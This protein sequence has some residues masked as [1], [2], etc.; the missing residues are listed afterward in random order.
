MAALLPEPPPAAYRY[1][2]PA[3]P[4]AGTAV[5]IGHVT[6]TIGLLLTGEL[7]VLVASAPA[8]VSRAAALA[9]VGAVARGVMIRDLGSATPSVS[10]AAGHLFTQRHHDFRAP[11]TVTSTGDCAV[12]FTHRAD[13]VAVTVSGEL[14]YSL[15]VTAERPP[16][17]RAPQ[18]WFRRHEKEL[19]SIGLLL[20]VA[21]PVVPAHL[22]G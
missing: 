13:A 4:V 15:E 12:D 17:A 7:E 14:T 5:D 6:V 20:L 3:G 11:N 18:G 9:A 19:A 22:T 10:A 16:S 21:V 8:E 2:L 1:T